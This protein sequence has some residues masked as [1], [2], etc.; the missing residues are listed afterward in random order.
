MSLFFR[1]RLFA[2]TLQL[3]HHGKRKTSPQR[4][5]RSYRHLCRLPG[6]WQGVSLRLDENEDGPL[7]AEQ[8]GSFQPDRHRAGQEGRVV[9]GASQLLSYP[10]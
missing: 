3:S 6:L 5:G 10:R 7:R 8:F 1:L 2:P 9:A 4:S